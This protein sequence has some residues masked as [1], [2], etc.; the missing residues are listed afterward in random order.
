MSTAP[1]RWCHPLSLSTTHSAP[2]LWCAPHL[3]E[4][5]LVGV[6][7]AGDQ[8]DGIAGEDLWVEEDLQVL[9]RRRPGGHTDLQPH[10]LS[11]YSCST[12]SAQG[13]STRDRGQADPV[14]ARIDPVRTDDH[15][16]L[17][18]LRDLQRDGTP[19][20]GLEAGGGASSP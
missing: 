13:F 20:Q 8:L 6:A 10:S 19:A 3:Q 9:D 5:V 4:Q 18:A 2:S 14:R 7:S 15:Q 17:A 11:A 16:V 1:K 12:D